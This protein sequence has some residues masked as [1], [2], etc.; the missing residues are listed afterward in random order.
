MAGEGECFVDGS[1]AVISLQ[2]GTTAKENAKPDVA[3]TERK[4]TERN[5][6]FSGEITANNANTCGIK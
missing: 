6:N 2:K 4:I 3:S 1:S 5:R